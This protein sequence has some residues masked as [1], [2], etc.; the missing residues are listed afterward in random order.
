MKMLIK[1]FEGDKELLAKS[2]G[3]GVFRFGRSDFSDFVLNHESISRSQL[4]L[5][6][7]E[8]S[9]YITN[10]GIA[11]KVRIVHEE[12]PIGRVVWVERDA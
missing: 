11:G 7:T 8:L 1:I 9:A 5:R 3:D 4:E 2:V 6:I 10:M 12:P